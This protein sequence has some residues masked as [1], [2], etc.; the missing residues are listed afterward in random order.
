MVLFF[1]VAIAPW[2]GK[3]HSHGRIVLEAW[4]E[5]IESF[6]LRPRA[7]VEPRVQLASFSFSDHGDMGSTKAPVRLDRWI[8]SKDVQ[9]LFLSASGPSGSL[10]GIQSKR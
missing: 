2:Q 1:A 6:D 4:G 10:I 8:A 7:G 9:Q 5:G 3:G